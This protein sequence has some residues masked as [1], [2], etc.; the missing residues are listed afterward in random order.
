MGSEDDVHNH[1]RR[2]TQ[3]RKL[4]KPTD[5]LNR[6]TSLKFAQCDRIQCRPPTAHSSSTVVQVA[7]ALA[8]E[9]FKQS[10]IA[11]LEGLGKPAGVDPK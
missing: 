2:F 10:G 6:L 3:R 7:A 4:E 5:S 8:L 9:I 1:I 11:G